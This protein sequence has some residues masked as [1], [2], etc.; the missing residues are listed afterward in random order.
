MKKIVYSR[1]WLSYCSAHSTEVAS[2]K[3]ALELVLEEIIFL[4]NWA[5]HVF[6]CLEESCKENRSLE[7]EIVVQRELV[8]DRASHSNSVLHCTIDG[9]ICAIADCIKQ[10]Y[11]EKDYTDLVSR[12][13][14]SFPI[15]Q[16]GNQTFSWPIEHDY[17]FR[18]IGH[19]VG[20]CSS[21]K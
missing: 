20:S 12:L 7:W 10:P 6:C 8:S 1:L 11:F 13:D 2:Y 17:S 18:P 5:C 19:V 4:N 16:L 3:L 14:R 9:H 15:G 21:I